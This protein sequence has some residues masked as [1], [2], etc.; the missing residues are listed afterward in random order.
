MSRFNIESLLAKVSEERPCGADTQPLDRTYRAIKNC[1][2]SNGQT[3]WQKLAED[4]FE[5]LKTSRHLEISLYFTLALLRLE[6]IPGFC[7]GLR[8]IH[9]LLKG[10]WEDVYPQLET[11]GGDRAVRR[12]SNLVKNL[13]PLSV[14]DQDPFQFKYWLSRTVLCGSKAPDQFSWRD[15]QIAK[16]EIVPGPNERSA[17]MAAVEAAFRAAG[18]GGLRALSDTLDQAITHVDG[19]EK[20]FEE[21]APGRTE[22]A[23]DG[24]KSDLDNIRKLVQS[25]LEVSPTGVPAGPEGASA[26]PKEGASVRTLTGGLASRQQAVQVLEQVCRYFEQHEP[27]SPVPLLLRRAQSLVSKGF[28]EIIEDLCPGA[29][30]QAK[31]VVGAGDPEKGKNSSK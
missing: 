6:G 8:L 23:L 27:S 5:L 24:L 31:A 22:L 19:I 7:Q 26:G 14:T 15:I 25:H 18:P 12:R 2:Q 4:S 29:M 10:F 9:E 21:K 13:S 17:E 3:N 1:I 20:V 28:L 11:D 30:S 16:Q